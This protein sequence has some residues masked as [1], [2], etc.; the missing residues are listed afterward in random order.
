MEKFVISTDSTSDFTT[1]EVKKL[2]IYVGR[3]NFTINENNQLNEYLDNFQ[4]HEEYVNFYNRLRKGGISKTSILNLQ[5]HIDLFTQMAKDGVKNAIHISQAMGLSPTLKNAEAAIEEVKKDFPDINYVAIESNSTTVAEGN[6]VKV[7][8]KLREQGKSMKETLDT[9]STL[10]DQMQHFI[11]VNDLMYLKRGG[12]ISGASAAFGTMLK[13]KPIIEFTKVGKL[14]IV[15]KETGLKKAFKSIIENVKENFT[16]HKEFAYPIIA[17]SDNE[18]D[19]QM[20]A[21]MFEDTFGIKPEIRII[22][23]IIGTHVGPNAV[24]LTFISNELRK[25]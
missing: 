10:K 1:Q 23:P 14:E 25:Y 15:K 20:L 9:L 2:G 21:N 8:L 12:R 18:S 16:F 6:L 22:G 7:A 17:H 4:S 13:I 19:A 3:L 11:V 24:A 5:A